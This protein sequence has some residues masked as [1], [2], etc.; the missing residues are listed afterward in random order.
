MSRIFSLPDQPHIEQLRKRLWSGREYGQAAVMVGSGFSRNAERLSSSTPPFPLWS[1]LAKAINESLYPP[2]DGSAARVNPNEALRLASEYEIAFGR[3]ALDDL[4]LRSIPDHSYYPGPLHELLLSLP[5]SD[6]FTTNYDTLLERTLPAIHDRKYDVIQTASDIPVLMRPRIVKL[7]G[8]FPAHRPFIITEEDFRTYPTKFPPF[9]NLVQQSIMENVFCLIGFSGDDPNFLYW[10]GWVRDNLGGATPHIYLC[11]LLNLSASQRKLL[12][13]KFIIPIDLSPLLAGSDLRDSPSRHAIV[14]EWFLK[15][16]KAGEPQSPKDWPEVHTRVISKPVYDLPPIL[17]GP[18]SL[19][20][21]GDRH[22]DHNVRTLELDK[23]TDLYKTWRRTREHY[24]GWVVLPRDNR[25]SLLRYTRYWVEPVLESIEKLTP[26]H[27]LLLLYELNW[28]LERSLTP[29]STDW[30][31]KLRPIVEAFNPYPRLVDNSPADI[32]PNKDQYKDWGNWEE[33]RECWVE[34]AF[35]LVRKA[36]EDQ[37]QGQ[38][39]L[40]L[41]R[42]EKVSKLRPEW[43]ARWFYE[44]CLF[45][46]YRLEQEQLQKTLEEWPA[47]ND[48]P[49]WEAKRAAI[50][51]EVGELKEAERIAE[52]ALNQIRSS[53]QPYNIDYSLLS[54]EGWTMLLLHT[55]KFADITRSDTDFLSQF[56]NRWEKLRIYRCDPWV[57]LEVLAS[58]VKGSNLTSPPAKEVKKGF[59]PG[60]VSIQ[61]K[62]GI[63]SPFFELQPAFAFL[64]M[65]EEGALPM[66]A[67]FTSLFSD[68][69][70]MAAK[71]VSL[72][73]PF[74]ALSSMIRA[75]KDE[76]IKEWFNRARIATLKPDEVIQFHQLLVPPFSQAVQNLSENPKEMIEERHLLT[77]NLGLLSELLSRMCFRFSSA[78]L[79]E[80]LQLT[81]EI[82]RQQVASPYPHI[83]SYVEKLFKRIFYAL[84]RTDLLKKIPELLSLPIPDEGGARIQRSS[85]I[86]DPFELIEWPSGID[87]DASYDRSSWSSSIARLLRIANE[88]SPVA[89]KHALNRLA[90]VYDIGGLNVEEARAFGEA[91]WSKLD[92]RGFPEHTNFYLFA[93][94]LLPEPQSGHAKGHLKQYL[95]SASFPQEKNYFKEW[96]YSTVPLFPDPEDKDKYIDWSS[97][98]AAAFLEKL[99]SWWDDNKTKFKV[100]DDYDKS[101][102]SLGDMSI[103]MMLRLLSRVIIPRLDVS[104]GRSKEA[105]RRLCSELEGTGFCIFP[106]LPLTLLDN[107]QAQNDVVVKL[108]SGMNSIKELDV[109][110]SIFGLYDWLIYGSRNILPSAPEDLL[111]DLV[112]RVIARRQ[113]GLDSAIAHVSAIVHR[114]P[115]LLNARHLDSLSIALNYLIAETR[116]PSE[117][118]R[119]AGNKTLT[120]I[121][122]SERSDYRMHVAE[123]AYRL[124]E[125]FTKLGKEIPEVLLR[126]KDICQNDPLPE[127]RR[128]W[129]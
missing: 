116:L 54:K 36:R 65:F 37:H 9:V 61:H 33:V 108:R 102:D 113:P 50:L 110:Y 109:R 59:D 38:Y 48:L 15:T 80:L 40:W 32:R 98:E 105:V 60:M 2:T 75:G 92:S 20:D 90:K 101:E 125:H 121:P 83:Y 18:P 4:L 77:Q 19:P 122:V 57:E 115:E 93:F 51:A 44:K 129:K 58:V 63:E 8:S 81:V 104:D 74:W 55:L 43:V 76:T 106:V 22:P 23:L 127:V 17:P 68:A 91:L 46:L 29:L 100:E 24:P 53:L 95:L 126:W 96:L 88:D 12:E 1:D 97:D 128:A 89:R 66:R 120:V 34:L 82:F 72:L 67:G 26:P 123:L 30:A 25:D 64:R 85:T 62:H 124:Y 79:E 11:G 56:G 70:A 6:I 111:S 94:L 71:W 87:L 69:A 7:H 78:Q 47:N 118:E 52:A 114:L 16:L 107:P 10:T 3:S 112:D 21:P 5:W 28:R 103:F 84:S 117:E 45:H 39:L 42:L 35:S 13:H 41:T 73:T 119:A 99:T 27:N 49:F 31:A 86:T 14:L